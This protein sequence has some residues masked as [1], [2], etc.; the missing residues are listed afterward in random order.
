[1]IK[2]S[3]K[4][5]PLFCLVAVV[6]TLSFG[7]AIFSSSSALKTL[8]SFSLLASAVESGNVLFIESSNNVLTESPKI[9]LVT[10]KDEI[11]LNIVFK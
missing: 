6:A 7:V 9:Y 5:E 8:G 11:L 1:M 3:L 10:K 4:K 2:G